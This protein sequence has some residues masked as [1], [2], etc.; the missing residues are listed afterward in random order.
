MKRLFAVIFWI[1]SL[2]DARAQRPAFDPAAQPAAPDYSQSRYWA[3]LPFRADAADEIPKTE[4]WIDDSLKTVDVFYVHPTLYAK[5]ETWNADPGDEKLN[6]RVDRLPV[7][8]QASTFNR[9]ARVYAPRY[10]QAVVEVFYHPS[11]DGE[12]ALDFAYADVKEAFEYYLKHYN[13]GRPFI[14]ASHSQ[15]TAHCRR[16]LREF[17][18]GK[19][20][21][22]Q[23]V[24]GYLVG[25][26]VNERMY[27]SIRLCDDSLQTGCYISWLSYRWGYT[28]KNNFSDEA[29][30]V[31]PLTWTTDTGRVNRRDAGEGGIFLNVRKK[32]Y[33]HANT[34]RIKGTHLWV[35]TRIPFFPFL[36]NMHIIDY[37][38]FWYD[39]RKNV[40]QRVKAYQNSKK[41]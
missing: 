37:N 6:A 17:I 13:N 25:Y 32:G 8:F 9:T 22:N 38:L 5:G 23:F 21:A 24:A 30:S 1:L 40:A 18:D 10:R 39:I 14:I 29:M 31:N 33:R 4:T 11:E 26:S 19:P 27:E 20:L 15:G 12:K 28:P 16:L 3:A 35:R 34:V 36:R 2:S 41:Q 7:R